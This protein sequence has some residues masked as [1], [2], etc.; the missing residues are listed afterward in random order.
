ME[1]STLRL[2]QK[3]TTIVL[4]AGPGGTF[5]GATLGNI[6]ESD[7]TAFMAGVI[8]SMLQGASVPVAVDVVPYSCDLQAALAY[9]GPRH[10]PETAWLIQIR[11]DGTP[12][13]FTGDQAS[14][15]SGVFGADNADS[16]AVSDFLADSFRTDTKEP[17]CWSATDPGS[18]TPSLAWL[19]QSYPAVHLLELG[20]M[21][22]DN[23]Q[24]HLQALAEIAARVLYR[25]LTGSTLT[26]SAAPSSQ[27]SSAQ[28]AGAPKLKFQPLG[29]NASI[30][31][32]FDI[33]SQQLEAL[34]KG[35]LAHYELYAA[36]IVEDGAKFGINPL[37]VLADFIS[38]NVNPDYRNPWG[39]SHHD[40]P[41]GPGG[42]QLGQPNGHV[43]DGPR[44]FAP[45]EWRIAFDRQFNVVASK[46]GV[47]KDAQ[48]IAQWARIDAPPGAKNDVRGTN[49]REPEV[50]GGLYNGLVKAFAALT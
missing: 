9:I 42:S 6:H 41:F 22:G 16:R 21:L 43:E 47:Y 26:L 35:S 36:A 33:T 44:M 32:Q 4:F 5:T 28:P 30:R 17:T 45:D 39:I 18:E 8:A 19:R 37:F 40:Y 7:Q 1:T 2:L 20:N 23:S 27:P 46:D 10:A 49:A 13:D 14:W 12:D 29:K 15:R 25:A 11:R 31:G 34:C 48:T 50:V 24:A 38:Q 3:S